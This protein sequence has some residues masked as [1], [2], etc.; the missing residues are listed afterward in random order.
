MQHLYTTPT[1]R[2]ARRRLGRLLGLCALALGLQ[3]P[4]QAQ[5]N[6]NQYTGENVAG[7]YT[8]LGSAGTAIATAN[9]DDANSAAQNIGFS[10]RYNGQNFTQFVLNTNGYLRLGSAAPSTTYFFSNP[11]DFEGGPLDS[12]NAADVNLLLPF[13]EDLTAGTSPTEYRV[14]TT[15]T[16][17]NRVCT[18]QWKNVSDKTRA[19]KASQY[20][21][22]SFQVKLYETSNTIEFVYGPATGGAT[23][24]QYKTVAIGLKGNTATSDVAADVLALNKEAFTPWAQAQFV[25]GVTFFDIRNTVTPDAGRTFR[26]NTPQANDAALVSVFTYGQISP[27]ATPHAP[28]ALVYNTGTT[29]LA[30]IPVTLTVSGATTF[31]STRTVTNLPAGRIALVSFP[32]YP[33]PTSGTNNLT[34]SIGNDAIN[35][36]NQQSVSQV[37]TTNTL[38]YQTP[39]Q[40]LEASF[41]NAGANS[42]FAAKY[43]INQSTT[44]NGVKLN[45]APA[46][47]TYPYQV[48]LYD[49]LGT[50]GGPGN[51][52]YTSTAQTRTATGGAV[53]VAIPNTVVNSS[54]FV[55]VRA[56]QGPL[57]LGAQVENLIV[58]PTTFYLIAPEIASL[59]TW[60]PLE[61][62]GVDDL[63]P[64]IDVTFGAVPPCQ[65]PVNLR[66]AAVTTTSANITFTTSAGTGPYVAEYGPVG[67]TPGS[68]TTV[69]SATSPITLTGLSVLTTYD[70]YVSKNCGGTAGT[71]ARYGPLKLTTLCQPAAVTF[72]YTQNF[73]AANT[74]PCGYT[75][76]DANNDGNT[77]EILSDAPTLTRSRPNALICYPSNNTSNDWVFTQALPLT[78]NQRYTASFYYYLANTQSNN[79]PGPYTQPANVE[80]FIGTSPTPAAMTTNLYRNTSLPVV[81]T[82]YTQIQGDAFTPPSAGSYYIGI[83]NN[84]SSTSGILIIDDL[85]ITTT[86]LPVNQA[87]SRAI[88]AYPN[89]TTG[90]LRLNLSASS[91]RQRRATVFNTLGQVV[92]TRTLNTATEQQLNLSTLSNGLYTVQLQLDND[93]VVKRVSLQK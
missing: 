18:I 90:I 30:S 31:T 19:P 46:T 25:A 92:L 88:E 57:G 45:F 6:Y 42:E 17:P 37:I 23:T 38:G 32:S 58:R 59:A 55:A 48:V 33:V 53:T 61:E 77:W 7:T 74:L 54:F 56:T 5:L 20:T 50:D 12:E 24:V 73:D 16:A 49:T 65:A 81:A 39:N 43:R 51:V 28:Q 8:D 72:P 60:T 44:V 78:A 26:F 69:A 2:S 21:N 40:D 34:V 35:G 86:T 9:T 14:A 85:S 89:P 80:V 22:L 11:D 36:N 64:A 29:T 41:P 68:G 63:R 13:N 75:I 27:E 79:Q 83:R 82:A 67:F 15:G 10:F 93:V 52:L 47:T 91:A 3:L 1:E 70:V 66:F 71:S 4:A 76:L 87:L 84:G 62:T